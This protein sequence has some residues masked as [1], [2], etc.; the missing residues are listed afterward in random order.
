MENFIT[1]LVHFIVI[2]GKIAYEGMWF[3]DQ[4]TGNGVL[5]NENP[6]QLNEPFN[7]ENFDNVEE[8]WTKYEGEFLED[9]KNGKGVF[10]LSNGEYFEGNFLNDTAQG[11]GVY[12][13]ISG[14]KIRGIW[15]MNLLEKQFWGSI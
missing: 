3:Q 8:S 1:N 7:Y 15:E 2:L 11:E 9:S 10:Y 13:T 4:F 12:A 6:D 5:Y 14:K